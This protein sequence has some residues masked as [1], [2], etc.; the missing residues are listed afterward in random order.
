M[1][2]F[3]SCLTILGG[4]GPVKGMFDAITESFSHG[5][6]ELTIEEYGDGYRFYYSHTNGAAFTPENP[7]VVTLN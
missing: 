1:V 7:H 3:V 2:S 6:V 5:E 4:I